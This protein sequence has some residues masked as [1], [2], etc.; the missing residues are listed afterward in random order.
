MEVLKKDIRKAKTESQ[1][2]TDIIHLHTCALVTLKSST[3]SLVIIF[4]GPC[5]SQ[6]VLA[7]F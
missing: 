6:K 5:R 2:I 1:G 4:K 7:W 3:R